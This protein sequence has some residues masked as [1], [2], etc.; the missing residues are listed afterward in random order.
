MLAR[1]IVDRLAGL[2]CW[3]VG[4]S[5]GST[6]RFEL[7]GRFEAPTA[8]GE[9]AMFGEATLWLT[10]DD[11]IIERNGAF[12]AGSESIDRRTAEILLNTHFMGQHLDEISQAP[13]RISIRFE[14]GLSLLAWKPP[15]A[16][17]ALDEDLVTIF[18]PD[19]RIAKF[20][21]ADGLHLSEEIDPKR[22]AFRG[23]VSDS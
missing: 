21:V 8:R 13:A 1:E 3:Q 19:G 16:E 18:L 23:G 10:G 14:A 17:I 7:G 22:A 12:L 2:T 6:L 9:K 4:L 20:N 15:D 11:W 5:Y